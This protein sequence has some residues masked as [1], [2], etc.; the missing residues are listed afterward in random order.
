MSTFG[1]WSRRSGCRFAATGASAYLGDVYAHRSRGVGRARRIRTAFL[2][3]LVE[4]DGVAEFSEVGSHPGRMTQTCSRARSRAR[5]R[6][7]TL[8]EPG[9]D[10][11]SRTLGLTLASYHD[12]HPLRPAIAR[13]GAARLG[14]GRADRYSA[15]TLRARAGGPKPSCKTAPPSGALDASATRR[16][17]RRPAGRNRQPLTRSPVSARSWRGGSGRAR[18][19]GRPR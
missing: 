4:T 18:T 3:A 16:A 11:G 13:L 9:P 17:P 8:T 10:T 14:S 19:A 5:A 15:V 12:W 7:T 1:R 2:L 6:L